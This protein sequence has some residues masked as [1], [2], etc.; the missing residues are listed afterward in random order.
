MPTPP[1]TRRLRLETLEDRRLL[2]AGDGP[3]Y[4][5]P[6]VPVPAGPIPA[7]QRPPDPIVVAGTDANDVITLTRLHDGRVEVTVESFL[8]PDWTQPTGDPVVRY[9][10]TLTGDD[11]TFPSQVDGEPVGRGL[12]PALNTI[13][14][15]PGAGTDRIE[16]IDLLGSW[17]YVS[18]TNRPAT[19]TD[20]AGGAWAAAFD[21][22]P[23]VVGLT[24]SATLDE[25]V[26]M[27]EGGDVGVRF[28]AIF[29][30][31]PLIESPI[32][33]PDGTN[34]D[35]GAADLP[36]ADVSAEG[37]PT[38]GPLTPAILWEGIDTSEAD[39]DPGL[40]GDSGADWLSG[41]PNPF[42]LGVQAGADRWFDWSGGENAY[43]LDRSDSASADG[44][45]AW[46]ETNLETQAP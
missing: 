27:A 38:G 28:A 33:G 36:P 15:E 2:S 30:T 8:D 13:R 39:F 34:P 32:P 9:E 41:D 45:D 25:G 29:H 43:G 5:M 21:V 26:N 24:S 37:L 3:P 16:V 4:P 18:G 31:L 12:A 7:D 14:V 1:H 22:M 40:S 20:S 46:L 35:G 44:M 11:L 19:L 17:I 10:T 6:A 42:G 23:C